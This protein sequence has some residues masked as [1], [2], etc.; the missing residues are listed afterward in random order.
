MVKRFTHHALI[1]VLAM[2]G[3]F[4]VDEAGAQIQP[5]S[6]RPAHQERIDITAMYGHMWGGN[7]DAR[8]GDTNGTLRLG[9]APSWFFA[10]DIPM[11]PATWV[12]LSYAH[13]GGELDWDVSLE[14]KTKLS[15]LSIN[16]WQIG[17]V[18]GMP[19]GNIIP[20]ASIALGATY[21]SPSEDRFT[22]DDTTYPLD[23]TTKFS[24]AL[25][26]GVKAFFGEAEQI[27]I[28]ASFRTLPTFY[29]TATGLWFGSG[30]AS[31]SVGGYAIWQWEAAVGLV[32]RVG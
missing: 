5:R 4:V 8:L 28:R 20:Y 27:G 14:G 3:I 24:L 1:A 32:L 13:Q 18:Q 6:S 12:E 2:A 29:N 11:G 10:L 16:Y 25:G 7:I 9:T 19:R 23:A 30:G 17:V 15:D 22:I 31:V 21:I 26:V